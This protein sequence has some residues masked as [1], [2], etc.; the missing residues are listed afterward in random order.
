MNR[1]DRVERIVPVRHVLVSTWDKMG[2]EELTGGIRSLFPEAL[3]YST[4]G[5]YRVLRGMIPE[6]QLVAVSD[7]TG[8][9]E[10]AGGLVKTLDYKLYLGLLSERFNDD[11]AADRQRLG[12]VLFDLV[13][14]NLYPFEAV[15]AGA[16]HDL[17]DAR[18]NIDIGGPTMVRAAAKN[19]LQVACLS[20]PSQYGRFLQEASHHGA[21]TL[22]YRYSLAVEAFETIAAYDDAISRYLR[23]TEVPAGLYAEGGGRG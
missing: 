17:E 14:C 8:Q 23:R 12:A 3:F 18:G 9:P 7:Y 2:L 22:E 13:A 4:G 10:I 16:G 19:F 6:G 11:H 20:S 15:V 5:T 21:T 1:V